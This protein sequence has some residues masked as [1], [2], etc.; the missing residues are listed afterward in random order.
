MKTGIELIADER[1]EQI[2]RFG[3]TGEHH[4]NHPEWYEEEQLLSASHMLSQYEKDNDITYLYRDIVPLNWSKDWWQKMCDKPK[5]ERIIIAGA[6]L[7]AELDRKY[8]FDSDK[9]SRED[10][11]NYNYIMNH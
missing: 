4:V 6:L 7:A 9:M 2:E 10:W 3:F 5:R 8:N 11:E 1:K